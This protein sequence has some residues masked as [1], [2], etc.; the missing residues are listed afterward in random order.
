[1][2]FLKQTASH[3]NLTVTE[4]ENAYFQQQGAPK[5]VVKTS[6]AEGTGGGAATAQQHFFGT[7]LVNTVAAVTEVMQKR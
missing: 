6:S 2:T 5:K 4:Q 1:V 3:K 7:G